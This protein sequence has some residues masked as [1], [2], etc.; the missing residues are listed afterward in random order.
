MPEKDCYYYAVIDSKGNVENTFIDEKCA[1]WVDEERLHSYRLD[2]L[3]KRFC[4]FTVGN[5]YYDPETGEPDPT[6]AFRYNPA[7]IGEIYDGE[8]EAFLSKDPSNTQF[9]YQ[10]NEETLIW[11]MTPESQANFDLARSRTE[12]EIERRKQEETP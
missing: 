6:K 9:S 5:I 4:P 3:V 11:E 10:L 12:A 2:K 1:S 7:V 8:R